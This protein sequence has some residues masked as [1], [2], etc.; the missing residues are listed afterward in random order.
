[1]TRQGIKWRFDRLLNDV[2]A[3]SFVTLLRI[4]SVIGPGMRFQAM[5]IARQ[6]N[7][8][9]KQN[10]DQAPV[11]PREAVEQAPDSDSSEM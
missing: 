1:M 5:E 9:S 6:R 10:L 3:E 2:Y 7:V 11:Y 8:Q 4:E